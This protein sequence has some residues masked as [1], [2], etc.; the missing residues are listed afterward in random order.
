MILYYIYNI[1]RRYIYSWCIY[2]YIYTY[3][4]P[5]GPYIYIYIHTCRKRLTGFRVEGSED[6]DI[7]DLYLVRGGPMERHHSSQNP[8]FRLFHR[9]KSW[10]YHASPASAT[11][12]VVMQCCCAPYRSCASKPACIMQTEEILCSVSA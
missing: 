7:F 2:I 4:I 1:Y 8:D 11:V 10:Q 9:F 6:S 5:R 12:S 3:I